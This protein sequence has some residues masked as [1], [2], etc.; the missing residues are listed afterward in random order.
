MRYT[1]W[2][3]VRYNSGVTPTDY[4]Y[5]GQYSYTAD[6]GLMFYNARWYDP[7][8]GRFT[9]ADTIVPLQQGVQAWDRY[10]YVNNNPILY[11]DPSGH[12]IGLI[13]CSLTALGIL[14]DIQGIAN[15][16]VWTET[17]N[18]VVAA[19]IAV[20]SEFFTG[21]FAGSGHGLAQLTSDEMN[22]FELEGSAYSSAVA[23]KGMEERIQL[24]LDNCNAC[25]TE[26]DNLIVA[27]LAQNGFDTRFLPTANGSIDWALVFSEWGNTNDTFAK[28]RQNLT[29]MN[30]GTQF[31]AKLYMQDL[32]ILMRLGYD[33][34]E[35][36]DDVDFDLIDSYINPSSSGGLS[37]N[38]Q[39]IW[40]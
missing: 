21:L 14:P 6:F 22:D 28:V 33:L 35:N 9:Q 16:I 12:C 27:A 24:A 18:A 38:N 2:G 13:T 29:D 23:V 32:K 39:M 40:R 3:E 20:Q 17:D 30:F 7:A 34:P 19:G 36:F 8:L 26:T 1:A 11:T 5:T 25:A 37:G 4:T 15:V 31:M 10:A